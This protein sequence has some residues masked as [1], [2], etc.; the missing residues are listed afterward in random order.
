M[1]PVIL[2]TFGVLWLLQE[3]V[4]TPL[5]NTWPVLLIVIGVLSF[6]ARSGSMEGHIQPRWMGGAPPP[7]ESNSGTA[8]G[9]SQVK[10]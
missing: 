7:G 5:E 8:G 1:G 2:I 6:A 3:Y 4:G 10:L 9:D